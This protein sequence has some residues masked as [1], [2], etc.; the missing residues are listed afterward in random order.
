[1]GSPGR[2]RKGGYGYQTASIATACGTSAHLDVLNCTLNVADFRDAPY[3][4][5]DVD[6]QFFDDITAWAPK[7]HFMSYDTESNALWAN[8]PGSTNIFSV[9]TDGN[10]ET[11]NVGIGVV[12]P[13]SALHVVR[14]A[15]ALRL[16]GDTHTFMEFYPDGPATRKAYFG[17]GS[18]ASDNLTIRNEIADANINL[19]PSGSLGR[20]GI[21]TTDP[22][23]LLEVNGYLTAGCCIGLYNPNTAA[24]KRMW[25]MVVN[26][27]DSDFYLG[28]RTDDSKANIASGT[29]SVSP[30]HI[31]NGA[32]HLFLNIT[33]SGR[34]GVNTSSPTG[35]LMIDAKV[36]DSSTMVE[37]LRLAR[38][39]PYGQ[40][41]T[42]SLGHAGHLFYTYSETNNAKPLVFN[43]T[44][45]SA[46]TTPTAG[47]NH[48][49]FR[50]RNNNILTL[51]QNGNAS[52]AGSMAQG[53]DARLKAD[54]EPLSDALSKLDTLQGVS[55][56]W[57]GK[58]GHTDTESRY[59]GLLAQDVQK[60]FPEAV[61]ESESGYLALDYSAMT[62]PLVEAVKT[63]HAENAALSARV[64]ALE[65]NRVPPASQTTNLR[66][67]AGIIAVIGIFMML[68]GWAL[69]T[70]RRKP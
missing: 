33:E 1:M 63:L 37:A 22:Q 57:N 29:N 36:P 24:G 13:L 38:N 47:F 52:L 67:I 26:T 34:L 23:N 25:R 70:R 40:F 16:Q 35:M 45:D 43:N 54:I 31:E 42:F 3:N 2:D 46:G 11:G 50:I 62:A 41:M 17:F 61:S 69:G 15:S 12:E 59:M 18:A 55:Y 9:G 20:V 68:L 19:L 27:S 49:Y 58:D 65:E 5:G 10:W 14:N 7:F 39:G 4:N 30:F 32:P 66:N 6:D 48:I 8:E 64:A 53:S 51:N 28:Y 44:T 60:V 21:G 56:R